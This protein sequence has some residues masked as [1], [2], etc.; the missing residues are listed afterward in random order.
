MTG[1]ANPG[2]RMS[3]NDATL[4]DACGSLVPPG[5]ADV[6]A[7][8]QR[9]AALDAEIQSACVILAIHKYDDAPLVEMCSSIKARAEK[10]E[11]ELAEERARLDE[12]KRILLNIIRVNGGSPLDEEAALAAIDEARKA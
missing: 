6:P 3:D 4:C 7:L 2:G 1:P 10:A 9:I 12:A 5:G 11:R 8:L